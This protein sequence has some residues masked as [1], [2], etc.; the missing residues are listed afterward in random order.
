[1]GVSEK[2]LEQERE[3]LLKKYTQ[4]TYLMFILLIGILCLRSLDVTYDNLFFDKTAIINVLFFLFL[5]IVLIGSNIDVI[6]KTFNYKLDYVF[7]SI[8]LILS[9]MLLKDE[10][11]AIYKIILLMPVVI[12]ALNYGFKNAFT[13]SLLSIISL[14]AISFING[15]LSIEADIIL[16]GVIFL[17]AW[18][19]GNM[20][21]TEREIRKELKR[22]ATHDEL[23]DLYNH[24]SF[25]YL[26]DQELLIAKKNNKSVSLIIIDIDYFKFYNDAY[27]HQQGDKALKQV[28][29]LMEN[30]VDIQGMCARYGGEEFTVILPNIDLSGAKR[31][32]EE[33]RA[34]IEKENIPGSEIL[35]KGQLTVSIG[36]A[37]YP[38]NANN[39]EKLIQLA[40]E[41]LYKAKFVSKN[42]VE[43]YYSVFDELSLN[44][45]DRQKDLFNSIKALTMVIHA[46]DRYT[47]G[48]SER[49]MELSKQLA[50]RIGL[51]KMAIKQLV[52]GAL[53]H[54][55]GKIE[56]DREILN[57]PTKLNKDEWE[58]MKQH[59][60]WG[61]DIIR[62]IESFRGCHDIILYHHENYDGTGYPTGIKGLDIPLGARILRIVDSYDAITTNR[63]YKSA[64]SKGQALEEL[65]RFAGTYYDSW[66]LK[67]FIAMME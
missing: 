62:P 35:P 4:I 6:N 1:M 24:R 11:E 65:N 9:I 67:E 25:Q 14:F 51:D 26:L 57:K 19:L 58:T 46:K 61:A 64:M 53:L 5:G 27:G 32:G 17:L 66:L 8:Y 37:E 36:I 38:F 33:I 13:V 30:V 39:K 16:S 45:K 2:L 41:A 23:T 55:I 18:L 43:T 60:R 15:F 42:R 22:L 40:D 3:K 49:T 29:K 48:H 7:T 28:A 31:I 20:T 34:K 44:L 10:G 21:D 50:E 47:Y 63:T 59:P 52:Y 12:M 56:I 54:D